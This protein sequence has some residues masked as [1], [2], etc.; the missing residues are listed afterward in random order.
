MEHNVEEEI[1]LAM[2]SGEKTFD[3]ETLDKLCRLLKRVDEKCPP[4]PRLGLKPVRAENISV[5][6]SKLGG[7]PYFPKEMEYPKVFEGYF[8]GNPL[9]LLA[10]LNFECLPR[11]EGFPDKG[12]LQFFAGCDGDDVI[13]AEFDD[14]FD[15]NGFRVIYHENIIDDTSKLISEADM[16]RFDNE[17]DYYPFSGEFLLTAGEA[18]YAPVSTADYRFEPAV[19]EA[20]NE[21][22]GDNITGMYVTKDGERGMAQTDRQLYDAV[23]QVR[24]QS[25]SCIGG[26]PFFTQDDPRRYD[27]ECAKCDITLFQLDSELSENGKYEDEIMWGDIGVGNFF[28]SSEALAKRDF[29]RVLYTWDCG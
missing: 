19:V 29:S 25:G 9:R 6:D 12:I 5:F 26:Y 7:V 10:Q 18:R 16:P 22:F 24:G 15:Q 17:E 23:Y 21:L 1:A 13:G 14:H 2:A 20:F 4:K 11:V 3:K 27:S 8:A 28:I